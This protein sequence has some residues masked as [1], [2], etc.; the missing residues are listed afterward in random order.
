MVRPTKFTEATIDRLL[1]A[2]ELGAAYTTACDHAGIAVS[3]FCAWR[4]G[5]FPRG[6]P[7]DRKLRFSE[8]L[9]R[10]IAQSNLRDLTVIRD[11]AR[12]GDWNV[13][14]RGTTDARTPTRS[15]VRTGGARPQRQ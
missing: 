8:G 2:I 10:A 15:A 13:A 9:G 3:T 11:A 1:E 7:P 12:S 6:A 14:A 5:T 4:E